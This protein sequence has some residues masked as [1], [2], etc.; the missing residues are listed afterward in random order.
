MSKEKL[1]K[2]LAVFASRDRVLVVVNADPDAMASALAL[3]RLLWRHVASCAIARVNTVQRPDNLAMI[4]LLKIEMLPLRGLD[5]TKF[6]R[7]VIVDSQPDHHEGF[8][9]INYDVVID[10]HPQGEL[11]ARF[12]DVRPTWGATSSI[13]TQYLRAARIR[14]SRALATALCLGIKTDTS[15]FERKTTIA[16][17]DAFQFL[18]QRADQHT[19]RRIEQAELTQDA[20]LHFQRALSLARVRQHR[21]DICLGPVPGHDVCVMI[22]DFFMRVHD[23]QWVTV[24]G[25]HGGLLVVIAR[26]DGVRRDAGKVLQRAFGDVGKA[27]GHR[28]MARAEVAMMRIPAEARP[29]DQAALARWIRQRMARR[30]RPPA[31]AV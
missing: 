1:N 3:K 23:V 30:K 13:L 16:D 29:E 9:G 25:H 21:A 17:V 14:P 10:H 20:L 4:R 19:M 26:S 2:L 5:L 12:V 7:F 31:A 8:A 15:S 11:K 6:D 28:N 18:F 24:A 27:G 22:A